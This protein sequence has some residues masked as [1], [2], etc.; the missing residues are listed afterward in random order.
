MNKVQIKRLEHKYDVT[1]RYDVEYEKYFI[2]F[3]CDS[4]FP[5]FFF[6]KT[7]MKLE[8]DFKHVEDCMIEWFQSRHPIYIRK[9]K[10]KTLF[11]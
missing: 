10:I 8:D 4:L 2:G 1:I 9:I 3:D 5:D 6:V 7:S 11:D